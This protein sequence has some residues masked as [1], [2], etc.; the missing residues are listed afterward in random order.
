LDFKGIENGGKVI[1]FK[2][3]VDNSTDNSFY[4]PNCILCFGRICANCNET[5]TSIIMVQISETKGNTGMELNYAT[6]L[7][8]E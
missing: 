7:A 2:L 1:G 8:G 6:D 4:G 3:N 5:S